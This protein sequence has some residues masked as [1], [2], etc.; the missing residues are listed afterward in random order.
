MDNFIIWNCENR[1]ALN[2]KMDGCL[3]IYKEKGETTACLC[4][5]FLISLPKLQ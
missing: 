1:N 2:E 4:A 3:S 5:W